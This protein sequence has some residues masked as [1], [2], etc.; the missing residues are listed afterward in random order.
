M[1]SVR[2]EQPEFNPGLYLRPKFTEEDILAIKEAFDTYDSN[3]T[4]L[5]T[6]NDLK[7]ALFH[8]GFQASKETVYNI[9]AEYDEDCLGGVTFDAFMTIISG[10]PTEQEAEAELKRVFRKMDR[11]NKGYLD[12][13]DLINLLRSLGEQW[14]QSDLDYI[15]ERVDQEEGSRVTYEQFKKIM[16]SPL[17]MY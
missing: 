1:I 10:E 15:F 6:P 12:P 7:V 17:S 4:G 5:L 13:K 11:D 14:E 8:N 2:K 9:I 3:K 16:H